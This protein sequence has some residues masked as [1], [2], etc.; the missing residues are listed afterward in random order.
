MMKRFCVAFIALL[1]CVVL[2]C[3]VSG[4]VQRPAANRGEMYYGKT[5]TVTT[6]NTSSNYVGFTDLH[7]DEW[8]WYCDTTAAPW[9][10]GDAV[11]LV[12]WDAGTDY[13]FDDEIISITVEGLINNTVTK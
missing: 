1:C 4:C 2:L 8:F 6:I 12:M 10:L 3:V 5:A 7:G 11:V 9:N 13:V